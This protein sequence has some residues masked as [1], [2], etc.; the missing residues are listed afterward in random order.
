MSC[1]DWTDILADEDGVGRVSDEA[2]DDFVNG[3][4]I[5]L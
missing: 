4:E 2:F 3:G 1:E 5:T